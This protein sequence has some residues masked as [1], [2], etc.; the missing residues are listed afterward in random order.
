MENKRF[1]T[2]WPFH[3][4][5]NINPSLTES[6]ILIDE[7]IKKKSVNYYILLFNLDKKGSYY[8]LH[9][10]TISNFKFKIQILQKKAKKIYLL[11]STKTNCTKIYLHSI[12]INIFFSPSQKSFSFFFFNFP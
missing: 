3:A 11:N 2:F 9:F 5:K 4:N 1:I 8:S 6:D 7:T 12:S 10:L